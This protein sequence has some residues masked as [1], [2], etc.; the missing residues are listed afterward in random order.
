[1]FT[2]T[3]DVCA[4]TISA[5]NIENITKKPINSPTFL[6]ISVRSMVYF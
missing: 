6:F 2:S 3:L 4:E 5:E 1:L